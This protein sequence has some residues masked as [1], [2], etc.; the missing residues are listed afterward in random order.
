MI[1][2]IGIFEVNICALIRLVQAS[3]VSFIPEPI[4]KFLVPSQQMTSGIG[5]ILREIGRRVIEDGDA[6]IS[7]YFHERAFGITRDRRRLT[8]RKR[9]LFV[10]PCGENQLDFTGV[11]ADTFRQCNLNR[12]HKSSPLFIRN[13]SCRR[14]SSGSR[15]FPTAPRA[16][17]GADVERFGALT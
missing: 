10:E 6:I 8:D 11:D 13:P 1:V 15:S 5:D 17:S 14:M 16:Q 9:S 3:S 12:L 2:S 4:A 7:Q